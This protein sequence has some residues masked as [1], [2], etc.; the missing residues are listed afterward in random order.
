VPGTHYDKSV[1]LIERPRED[2]RAYLERERFVVRTIADA[3]TTIKSAGRHPADV[4]MLDMT[5]PDISRGGAK[6]PRHSRRGLLHG[7]MGL[8]RARRLSE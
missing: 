7:A 3:L 8:P 2:I 4:I 5:L 6:S 1:L